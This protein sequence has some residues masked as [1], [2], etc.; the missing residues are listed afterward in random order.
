MNAGY[1]RI[2]PIPACSGGGR[3]TERTP[4][5]QPSRQERVKVPLS[6]HFRAQR[7]G[8]AGA[9]LHFLNRF[10]VASFDDLVRPGK[11]QWWHGEAE[12][13]GGLQ[14]EDQLELG[15]LLHG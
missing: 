5:I 11:Q 1:R 8:C 12:R 3:L 9:S 2:L 4:A 10:T 6:R 15:G 14:V 7:I 13:L